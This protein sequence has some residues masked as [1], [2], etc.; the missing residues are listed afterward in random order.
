MHY[1]VVLLP[2]MAV[3]FV[4]Y[5]VIGIAIPVGGVCAATM[6]SPVVN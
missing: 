3:V 1:V 2:I 6:N 4:A 5:F